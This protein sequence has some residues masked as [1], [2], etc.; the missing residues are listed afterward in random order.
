MQT[1]RSDRF[2]RNVLFLDAATC[3][4]CGLLMV[5]AARPFGQL[6]HLPPELLLYAGL[7]LF[8]IAGFFAWVGAKALHS[9]AALTAVIGGNLGWAIASFWLLLGGA[10][11]PNALGQV[12]IAAQAAV[13]LALTAAELKGALRGA[14]SEMKSCG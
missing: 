8:P 4:G 5:L 12:F 2:L 10:V 1:L 13:V 3:T 9:A 7:S 6:A 14:D 11:A